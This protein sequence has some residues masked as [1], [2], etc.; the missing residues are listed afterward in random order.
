MV[1]GAAR[2]IGQAIATRL[3]RDGFAVT[4]ADLESAQQA[5][6]EVVQE[7]SRHGGMA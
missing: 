6:G 4:V 7:I 1:T 2:G 5:A 3:A